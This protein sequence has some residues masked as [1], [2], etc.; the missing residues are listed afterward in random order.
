MINVWDWCKDE[1]NWWYI[2]LPAFSGRAPIPD[3]EVAIPMTALQGFTDA[4][5]GSLD[6]FG[7]G[8]GAFLPPSTWA[9]VPFGFRING[10]GVDET[11]KKL[12]RKMSAWELAGPLLLLCSMADELFGKQLIIWVDNSGSVMMF[13]KG[14]STKCNLCCS[15]IV[16]INDV[17]RAIGCEV[18]IRKIRR[19]SDL[20]SVAADKLSKAKFRDFH[21][22]VPHANMDYVAA[23]NSFLTWIQDPVPDRFLGEK[24]VSEM[25]QFYKLVS[26]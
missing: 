3:P 25:A 21:D 20:G 9:Y 17:A 12:C 19:C 5:G 2:Y 13:K 26:H 14:Y 11:G 23:P 4:A 24:I 10:P 7:N 8:I 1:L 18:D 16:A 6:S 15:L 22:L